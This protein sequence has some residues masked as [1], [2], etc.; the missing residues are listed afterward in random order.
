MTTQSR[1]TKIELNLCDNPKHNEREYRDLNRALAPVANQ[2]NA[3]LSPTDILDALPYN[4]AFI[5]RQG[6]TVDGVIQIVPRGNGKGVNVFCRAVDGVPF[7]MV[8]YLR[9]IVALF[10]EKL[11]SMSFDPVVQYCLLDVGFQK[12]GVLKDDVL[13]D[14]VFKDMLIF[15][16][17][18]NQQPT[19]EPQE[20]D[21]DEE[22]ED[23]GVEMIP[24]EA[25]PAP[26]RR[27]RQAPDLDGVIEDIQ[28]T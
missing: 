10:P 3:I 4:E 8:H 19:P 5:C 25:K 22:D 21:E 9:E 6:D 11:L 1:L 7:T 18:P 12:V 2:L 24:V 15:E 13:I 20:I 27:R 23:E 16:Y 17:F 14:G 26:T 28:I